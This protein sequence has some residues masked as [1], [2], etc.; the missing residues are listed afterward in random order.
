MTSPTKLAVGSTR[1]YLKRKDNKVNA[2]TS[3]SA[4]SIRRLARQG[5][6]R[7]ISAKTFPVIRS[8]IVQFMETIVKDA[9]TFAHYAKRKTVMMM[10]VIFA[11]KRHGKS[12]YGFTQGA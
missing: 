1:V 5:G 4:G 6:V 9:L 7:R 11:M 10:D 12:M 2:K 3:I 8:M